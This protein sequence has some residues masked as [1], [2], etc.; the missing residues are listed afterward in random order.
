MIHIHMYYAN[1]K[2]K[3]IRNIVRLFSWLALLL[4]CFSWIIPN[5][6]L[7]AFLNIQPL[8]GVLS[9]AIKKIYYVAIMYTAFYSQTHRLLITTNESAGNG[10]DCCP[11][12]S[13]TAIRTVTSH[14][15]GSTPGR[16]F[17]MLELKRSMRLLVVEYSAVELVTMWHCYTSKALYCYL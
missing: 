14:H 3:I 1:N 10:G 17:L 8:L 9:Y 16:G 6:S 15:A 5:V 13:L 11:H 2:Y 12:A 4:D 7:L